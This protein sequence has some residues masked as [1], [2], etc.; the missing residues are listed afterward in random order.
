MTAETKLATVLKA[1]GDPTRLRILK[2][3]ADRSRPLCVGALARSLGI[4]QPAVSQHLRV[5]RG[6][7]IVESHRMGSHV[8][9]RIS[10]SRVFAYQTQ[11][12]RFLEQAAE[13]DAKWADARCQ[14]SRG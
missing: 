4:S 6:L 13:A 5:L 2:L 8:H 1:L 9:Y 11:I 3:L 10:G 12:D 14:M 7:Q